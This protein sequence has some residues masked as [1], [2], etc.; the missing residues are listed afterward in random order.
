MFR[1]TPSDSIPNSIS[2]DETMMTIAST[3]SFKPSTSPIPSNSTPWEFHEMRSDALLIGHS[4][5]QDTPVWMSIGRRGRS[6]DGQPNTAFWD[7]HGTKR[8]EKDLDIVWNEQFEKSR[9][10]KKHDS[11]RAKTR[12]Q[13]KYVYEIIHKEPIR[14]SSSLQSA[15]LDLA[16]LTNLHTSRNTDTSRIRMG[17]NCG[18]ACET[19]GNLL[20]T[21]SISAGTSNKRRRSHHQETVSTLDDDFSDDDGPLVSKRSRYTDEA[22]QPANNTTD[23]SNDVE[24]VPTNPIQSSV[25]DG[26]PGPS[27]QIPGLLRSEPFSSA[28]APTIPGLPSELVEHTILQVTED[29]KPQLAPAD[30]R[31]NQCTTLEQLFE[32][33]IVE[34]RLRGT[35]AAELY[36]VSVTYKGGPN[37]HCIRRNHPSDWDKLRENLCRVWEDHP[38]WFLGDEYEVQ[39]RVHLA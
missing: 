22:T 2:T 3:G 24:H 35:A 14:P 37:D 11:E 31:L 36:R 19:G 13:R 18:A 1:A 29:D 30:I 32:T 8:S 27:Y 5:I 17:E 7:K 33:L 15:S 12:E 20:G 4:Y 9:F 23:S 34:C 16:D 21:R 6:Q 38:E 39:L 10:G 26:G 25:G 28:Q